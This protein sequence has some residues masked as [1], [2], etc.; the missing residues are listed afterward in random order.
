MTH[1]TSRVWGHH[2]GLV[3]GQ[4]TEYRGPQ[5]ISAQPKG[6]QQFHIS[7]LSS[8]LARDNS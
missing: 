2:G 7:M 1:L 5:R 6:R 4:L 8:R 3:L